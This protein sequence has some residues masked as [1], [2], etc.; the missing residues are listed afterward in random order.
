MIMTDGRAT[1]LEIV[2]F[3]V[4]FYL[5]SISLVTCV[6]GAVTR[7]GGRDC[8][9]LLCDDE[10]HTVHAHACACATTNATTLSLIDTTSKL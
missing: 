3:L 1:I 9:Q 2:R 7:G 10:P 4:H 5:F 8:A 6:T